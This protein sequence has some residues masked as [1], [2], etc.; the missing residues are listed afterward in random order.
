MVLFLIVA[1]RRPEELPLV[2][3]GEL[4]WRVLLVYGDVGYLLLGPVA[5]QVVERVILALLPQSTI[6]V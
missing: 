4:Y 5:D 1:A 3:L 6:S 2:L